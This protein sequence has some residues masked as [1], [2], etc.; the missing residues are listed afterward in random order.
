MINAI[1]TVRD[2]V[3]GSHADFGWQNL[4]DAILRIARDRNAD[5]PTVYLLWG[6]YAARRA[7]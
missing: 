6:S 3:A 2:G 4:T 5:D 7:P 1:L